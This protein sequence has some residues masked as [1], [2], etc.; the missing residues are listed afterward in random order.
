MR[1]TSSGLTLTFDC[2]PPC[3]PGLM[4]IARPCPV[5]ARFI[6]NKAIPSPLFLSGKPLPHLR[7][8]VGGKPRGRHPRLS[9]AAVMLQ[10]AWRWGGGSVSEGLSV[11]TYPMAIALCS[12]LHAG[13]GLW[14]RMFPC[15]ILAGEGGPKPSCSQLSCLPAAPRVGHQPFSP[16]TCSLVLFLLAQKSF[17]FFFF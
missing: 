16:R 1:R 5:S 7:E 14:M 17:F 2:C 13:P 12:S 15:R 9:W 6:H 3:P 10:E 8:Q 4:S 11:W